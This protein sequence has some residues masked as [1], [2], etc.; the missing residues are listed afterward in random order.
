SL[1]GI[2]R[3][4]DLVTTAIN[5]SPLN[6]VSGQ[7]VLFS[8]VVKNQ[9][10]G[11]TPD[12]VVI[13]VA[14]S[15]DGQTNIVWSEGFTASIPPD[16][17][18]VLTANAVITGRTWTA[19]AGTHAIRAMADD[20]NLLRESNESNN[21]FSVS[22]AVA[23][24]SPDSDGDGLDDASELIAGTDPANAASIFKIVSAERSTGQ[25]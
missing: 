3:L 8:A 13:R 18:V 5:S 14:F 1:Y 25:A 23:A 16:G 6:P 4:P 21:V 17:S 2:T 10:T 12:G 9:G 11:P 15:V 20:V 19:T 7:S 24:P 22:L